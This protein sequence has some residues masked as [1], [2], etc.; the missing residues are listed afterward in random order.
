MNMATVVGCLLL[1]INACHAKSP[2]SFERA[3]GHALKIFENNRTTLYCGCRYRTDKSVDLSSCN[4]D[5][6]RG[7]YRAD[8]IEWEHMMPASY[9]GQHF[10]CWKQ[11]LCTNNKGKKFRGRKCCQKIDKRFREIESELFNL[12]PANGLINEKRSNYRYSQLY[13]VPNSKTHN[14]YGCPIAID[15][16]SSAFEPS[17]ES[18]GIVARAMLFMAKHYSIRLEHDLESLMLY[19]HEKYPPTQREK[20]WD[21]KVAVIEGYHNNFI[22]G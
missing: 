3:K 18:K 2:G 13:P 12:W 21:K 15:Q 22:T 9:F 7:I 19:W 10:A 16:G 14:Y 20:D 8:R 4:M 6:A 11:S 1:I 5:K 17:E